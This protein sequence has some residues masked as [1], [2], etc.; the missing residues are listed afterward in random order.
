MNELD[1]AIL[2]ID[3]DRG[4]DDAKWRTFWDWAARVAIIES[5]DNPEAVQQ[6]SGPGRGKYQYELKKGGSGA[7]LT[8]RNRFYRLVDADV[9]EPTVRRELN[10][11]DPDFSKLPE[12]TQDAIFL[13]DKHFSPVTIL[14]DLVRH[15]I[16]FQDAWLDWHWMGAPEDRPSKVYMWQSRFGG[17]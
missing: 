12:E 14:G 11:L 7:N 6:P 10:K 8:A 2:N 3:K 1:W 13:A 17:S 9:L 4:W 5:N 16:S 15:K